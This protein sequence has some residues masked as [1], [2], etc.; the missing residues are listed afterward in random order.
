MLVVA[1]AMTRTEP[2]CSALATC[3]SIGSAKNLPWTRSSSTLKPATPAECISVSVLSPQRHVAPFEKRD[4]QKSRDESPHVRAE[5]D[6]A[7]VHSLGM[8]ENDAAHD[9]LH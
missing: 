1:R 5:R 4:E 9:E 8:R 7:R 6:A 2:G 3:E